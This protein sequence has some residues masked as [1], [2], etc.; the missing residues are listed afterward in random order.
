MPFENF[1]RGQK[2]GPIRPLD[3][4]RGLLLIR[5]AAPEDYA[6]YCRFFAEVNVSGDVAD[7]RA[8]EKHVVPRAF[9]GL[10][11][12]IP[13]AFL[14]WR[15]EGA[16]LHV[17]ILAVLPERRRRGLGRRMMLEAARRGRAHGLTRWQLNVHF[18][19]VAAQVFYAKLGMA[20]AF[21]SVLLELDVAIAKR[22]PVIQAGGTSARV[23]GQFG[24]PAPSVGADGS[25]ARVRVEDD[26]ALV[27]ELRAA[28][29]VVLLR[30]L[31]MVGE[32]PDTG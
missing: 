14:L 24:E 20:P 6:A 13:N 2:C 9:F 16:V 5:D 19:N 12:G 25:P 26:A 3:E 8:Y 23:V 27:S 4:T 30:A 15:P 29:G 7:A 31:R 17:T 32:M 10:E 11:S 28:G 21:E 22:F 1:R 18:E